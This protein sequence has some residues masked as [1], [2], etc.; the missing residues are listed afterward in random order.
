MTDPNISSLR[1]EISSLSTAVSNLSREISSLNRRLDSLDYR[2]KEFWSDFWSWA[3]A[4]LP[5]V[6]IAS[7][8]IKHM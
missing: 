4:C 2:L 3:V 7:L 8:M 1:Y 5:L 6:L